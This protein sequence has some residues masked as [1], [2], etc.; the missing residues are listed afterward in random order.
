MRSVESNQPPRPLDYPQQAPRGGPA[1]S[2]MGYGAGPRSVGP[3]GETTMAAT[4][5]A[6]PDSYIGA[7]LTRPDG[8][9]KVSGEARYAADLSLLGMLHVR[10]L[11]SPYA[12]ARIVGVER[13]AALG[14]PGV[15]AVLT[16]QDLAP[17]V[18]SPPSSR[19]RCLLAEG[20]ARYC[21]QPVVAVLA[22]SEAVAEDA[23][24][25]V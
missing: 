1:P 7:R 4:S 18:K 23:L 5:D 2:Q 9:P 12:H 8:P 6:T 24:A 15:V 11:L 14:L 25:L 16:A 13:Q 3:P 20:E 17:H 19:A 22:E 10:L 21:G